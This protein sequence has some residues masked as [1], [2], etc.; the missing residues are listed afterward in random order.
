MLGIA[1]VLIVNVTRMFVAVPGGI[2]IIVIPVYAVF[3]GLYCAY[4]RVPTTVSPVWGARPQA[5]RG[6]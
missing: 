5:A 2:L 3:G 4:S 6:A 1:S